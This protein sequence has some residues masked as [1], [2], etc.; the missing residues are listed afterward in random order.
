MGTTI[1]P[2]FNLSRSEA[3]Y[4]KQQETA[5]QYLQDH[6][7]LRPNIDMWYLMGPFYECPG[8]RRIG[9][10]TDG[11]QHDI[12]ARCACALCR[13]ACPNGFC[14]FTYYQRE[15][16]AVPAVHSLC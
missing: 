13:T 14:T 1:V 2:S 6:P 8:R 15:P 10:P 5:F 12:S 11:G 7:H 9:K 4:H 16:D 3:N